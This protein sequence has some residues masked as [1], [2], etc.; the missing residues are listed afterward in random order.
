MKNLIIFVSLLFAFHFLLLPSLFTEEKVV[1]LEEIVVTA[2]RIKEPKK[3]V[4]GF[5]QI[6][7]QEDIKNSTAKDVGELIAEAAIGHIHKYPGALTGGI[8]V[9]GLRT[10]L[11]SEFKSRILILINSHRAGTVNL[12]KLPV[13]DI[14]KIEIVKGPASVLYGSSAM[15]GVIN[16][17]TKEGKEE[18]I[19]RSIGVEMGSYKYWKTQAE[20]NGKKGAFDF[21]LVASRSASDDYDAKYYG[22]IENTGYNDETVST[23][24][25]WIFF[26]KHHIS[27]GFQHWKG[28]KIGSP[29]GR[30]SPDPDDYS[31]EGRDGFDIGYET[32][33]FNAKYYLTKDSKERHEGKTGNSEIY[34]KKT[35]TQGA[36]VQNTFTLDNH[37]IIIGGEWDR[38]EVESS[39][40]TGAPYNPN[41]RYDSY[42]AFTE[43]RLSLFNK[44]LLLNQGVRYDYFINE[45]LE[46]PGIPSLNPRKEDIDHITG[47]AGLVYRLRDNLNLKSNVGT[48]FRVP[49]PDELAAD[50]T[51][52]WGTRYLGNPDLNPENST[53]YDIG[54][55]YTN[56]LFK[57]ELTF[58]HTEFR[59]KI[60]SYYDEALKAMTFKNVDGAIL[61]GIEGNFSYNIGSA[62][63]LKVS[64]D[65]FANVTY[66]T[67]Y[68]SKDESEIN[69][70]GKNLLYTPK[71]T[72]AFGIRVGQNKW[73]VRLISNYTG[74]EK[75]QDWST[76]PYPV[77][78]KADFTVINLK[79]SYSPIKN[80]EITVSIEN[81]LDRAYEY[82]QYY[83]MPRRTGVVG[84]KWIF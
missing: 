81:L 62:M 54:P 37:R 34:L 57:S 48:A 38:I 84:V 49:A 10:D 42:G 4:P 16:I 79:C 55:N 36:S 35:D 45:I 59:D 75:V 23:R 51:S 25:G 83:P 27:L 9:R 71:W 58:F 30:Y 17:I 64:I 80:L 66:H 67:R 1:S 13:E 33:I 3:D 19:H 28:W 63:G 41:S 46:T 14:E 44:R 68:S 18:S 43:V 60:L 50:Y 11:F 73:W 78:E 7:T 82:V 20:L 26:D 2:T 77:V 61:Q 56:E 70:Y 22:K 8:G 69:K 52:S 39:R 32:E 47:R 76:P 72:G 29:G 74:D 15:G 5:V 65:P 6:I 12:A 31:D 21:Y 24:I 40:N 53:S